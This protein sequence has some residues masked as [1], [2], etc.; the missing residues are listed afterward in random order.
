MTGFCLTVADLATET[1]K[2]VSKCFIMLM[3]TLLD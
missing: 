1:G 3:E 2:L